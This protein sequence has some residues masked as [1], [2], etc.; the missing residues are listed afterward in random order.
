MVI[1]TSPLRVQPSASSSISSRRRSGPPPPVPICRTKSDSLSCSADLKGERAY[2][3]ASLS[4]TGLR[5]SEDLLYS[6]PCEPLLFGWRRN[7]TSA[8]ARRFDELCTQAEAIDA[9][10][11][12]EVIWGSTASYTIEQNDLVNW[13]VKAR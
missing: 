4:M 1:S 5:V 11:K 3:F 7:M 6:D 2:G 9:S 8:F 13:K 10:K 12:Q